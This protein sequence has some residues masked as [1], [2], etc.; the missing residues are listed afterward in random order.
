MKYAY[1]CACKNMWDVVKSLSEIDNVET[2]EK[3]GQ[4]GE[5]FIAGFSFYGASDWDKTEYNPGLGCITR[6]SKHRDQIARSRG[7]IEIGNEDPNKLHAHYEAQRERDH[8]QRWQE[9]GR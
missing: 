8:A 5:R 7:L 6:N 1:R 9:A 3:C 2:C 4:T